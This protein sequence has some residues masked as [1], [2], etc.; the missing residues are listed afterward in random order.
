MFFLNLFQTIPNISKIVLIFFKHK[1][2]LWKNFYYNSVRIFFINFQ[3]KAVILELLVTKSSNQASVS[4]CFFLCWCLVKWI[5]WAN[6]CLHTGHWKGFTPS[7][8]C[9]ICCV[10]VALL[11]NCFEQLL[12]IFK[13]EL[14]FDWMWALTKSLDSTDLIFSGHCSAMW[15]EFWWF[16]LAFLF[17]LGILCTSVTWLTKAKG[18]W[19]AVLQSVHW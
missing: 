10:R 4:A 6:S 13:A 8:T 14:E 12:H 7:W 1:C 17:W 16:G 15:T 5:F 9:K 3:V 11:V 19:K 2:L 18:V